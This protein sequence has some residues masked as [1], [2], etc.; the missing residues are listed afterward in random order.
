MTPPNA[1]ALTMTK[2][3][4]SSPLPVRRWKLNV[5]RWTFALLLCLP[6]TPAQAGTVLLHSATVHTVS[7]ETFSPG[8]VLIADGKILAVAESIPNQ[9]GNRIDLT[10]LHL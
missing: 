1:I 7:G 6:F 10:G 8:Q 5:L 9:P 2:R 4:I 3:L